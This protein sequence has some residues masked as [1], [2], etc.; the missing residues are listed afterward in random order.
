MKIR[1]PV[2]KGI[3]CVAVTYDGGNEIPAFEKATNFM[4][5]FMDNDKIFR[6]EQLSIFPKNTED[7]ITQIENSTISEIICKMCG[8]KALSRLKKTGIAVYEFSGYRGAA[9]DAYQAGKL[10]AL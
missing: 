10:K 7:L 5:Y 3:R 2:G 8:P 4:L 1:R 6:E 9:M